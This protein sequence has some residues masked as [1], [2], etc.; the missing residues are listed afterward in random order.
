LPTEQLLRVGKQEMK[1]FCQCHQANYGNTSTDNGFLL[2][3]HFWS[4][5]DAVDFKAIL[6]A[7][8]ATL[9]TRLIPLISSTNGILLSFKLIYLVKEEKTQL[10][11]DP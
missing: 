11:V 5:N 4:R 3:F 7:L 2:S 8:N 6:H 1:W 10:D 9:C